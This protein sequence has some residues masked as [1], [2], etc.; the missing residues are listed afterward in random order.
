MMATRLSSCYKKIM[1][2]ASWAGFDIL[3]YLPLGTCSKHCPDFVIQLSRTELTF[4]F[5]KL[6]TINR[7]WLQECVRAT[8][9]QQFLQVSRLIE[10]SV[11][12][13]LHY[14]IQDD[15]CRF[16]GDFSGR[17]AGG[18]TILIARL[19]LLPWC[20]VWVNSFGPRHTEVG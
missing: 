8:V 11:S 1:C 13:H 4:S 18:K 9:G 17:T 12:F 20:Q 16:T 10:N 7:S 6:A 14:E 3:L 2:L 5:E 15:T 19:L